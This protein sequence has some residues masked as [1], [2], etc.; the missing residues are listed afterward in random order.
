MTKVRQV[1]KM[2]F[3]WRHQTKRRKEGVKDSHNNS[4][5]LL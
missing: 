1:P 4:N 2:V 5:R 3:Y